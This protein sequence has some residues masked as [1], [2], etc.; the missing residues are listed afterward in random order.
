MKY[1]VN[2]YENIDHNGKNFLGGDEIKGLSAKDAE[3]LL[4]LNVITS[5]GEED[6]AEP[7]EPVE[8][9]EPVEDDKK[10]TKAKK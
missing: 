9:L 1:F 2:E 7:V 4:K 10:A 3:R 5:D 8:P 6:T